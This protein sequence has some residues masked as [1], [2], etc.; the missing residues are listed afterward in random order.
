[1]NEAYEPPGL[2]NYSLAL[3]WTHLA[4]PEITTIVVCVYFKSKHVLRV[5]FTQTRDSVN[6]IISDT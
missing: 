2:Q 6:K 1:M 4:T 5:G 3:L